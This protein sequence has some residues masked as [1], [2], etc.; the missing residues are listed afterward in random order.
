MHIVVSPY[1]KTH[2]SITNNFIIYT[3]VRKK[4][5]NLSSK[6][7]SFKTFLDDLKLTKGGITFLTY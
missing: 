4:K 5:N 3:E 7:R 1:N 2:K 6:M